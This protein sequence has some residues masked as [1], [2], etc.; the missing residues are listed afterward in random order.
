MCI[1]QNGQMSG[2][3]GGAVPDLAQNPQAAA[4]LL[5]SAVTKPKKGK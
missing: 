4:S 5:S 1:G 2:G 3:Q